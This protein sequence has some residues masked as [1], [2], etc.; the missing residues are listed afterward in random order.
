MIIASF[1]ETNVINMEASI[2]VLQI[3][4][5]NLNA[6]CSVWVHYL[7][8]RQL[9]LPTPSIITLVYKTDKWCLTYSFTANFQQV[10]QHL[11]SQGHLVVT[12]KFDI[13]I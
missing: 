2:N 3:C 1:T 5:L 9:A 13:Y 11:S 8:H 12:F 4:D 6:L 10:S 7:Y